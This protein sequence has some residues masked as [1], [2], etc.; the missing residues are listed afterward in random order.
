M[1]IIPASSPTSP[2]SP[3]PTNTPPDPV[4]YTSPSK[5]ASTLNSAL[6]KSSESLGAERDKLKRTHS[7]MTNSAAT[8]LFCG[9][10]PLLSHPIHRPPV[11][12]L[13]TSLQRSTSQEDLCFKRYVKIIAPNV[14]CTFTG[15]SPQPAVRER[16]FL[17]YHIEFVSQYVN[18]NEFS[19]GPLD[20]E[21][22][23]QGKSSSRHSANVCLTDNDCL[24]LIQRVYNR[25]RF[26]ITRSFTLEDGYSSESPS[27]EGFLNKL[28]EAM[29]QAKTPIE[30]DAAK[31]IERVQSSFYDAAKNIVRIQSSFYL[32]KGKYR[33]Y[34]TSTATAEMINVIMKSSPALRNLHFTEAVHQKIIEK[35]KAR[36]QTNALYDLAS[37]ARIE[38]ANWCLEQLPTLEIQKEFND[39]LTQIKPE[40][41]FNF[42][43]KFP[44]F[45]RIYAI[46]KYSSTQAILTFLYNCN[47]PEI[48]LVTSIDS[49]KNLLDPTP[50]ET[51]DRNQN[52]N[53]FTLK[54]SSRLTDIILPLLRNE[55]I[56]IV[57][58][59]K[60][61]TKTQELYC[62][63]NPAV[64]HHTA[65]NNSLKCDIPL[66]RSSK[67]SV[68]PNFSSWGACA[69]YITTDLN[70]S[71]TGS[72]RPN[73]AHSDLLKKRDFAAC[74]EE[75]IKKEKTKGAKCYTTVID[76][77][78]KTAEGMP[79]FTKKILNNIK[80]NAENYK[81]LSIFHSS[82]INSETYLQ[83]YAIGVNLK[84]DSYLTD[85]A[86][87]YFESIGG[88][89][90][91]R[92]RWHQKN[93]PDGV[94]VTYNLS[95]K[96]EIEKF[97]L[98]LTHEW[99]CLQKEH[100]GMF[101][102]FNSKNEPE[103]I[104]IVE[105]Q[106]DDS[107]KILSTISLPHPLKLQNKRISQNG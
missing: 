84:F 39:F 54:D 22:T 79:V 53:K 99:N 87:P 30:Q 69:R 93:Y 10:E 89:S 33:A 36:K 63:H 28:H 88:N 76:R 20:I 17:R 23:I 37:C 95:N 25:K 56:E 13:R 5:F 100:Q 51:E 62:Y 91:E 75:N 45:E 82:K 58:I 41:F 92:S 103:K 31:N 101:V 50:F 35:A 64:W 14:S 94:E 16:A 83:H 29:L 26:E 12:D 21:K 104:F 40:S 74:Y 65:A 49:A 96:D 44:N 85:P 72:E 66:N 60:D 9:A 11:T 18:W 106:V 48:Y 4:H 24:T 1:T 47:S 86:F 57:L 105:D 38:F 52:C 34:L 68:T 102:F 90:K 81:M 107:L 32:A 71:N 73:L 42:Y 43:L 6:R 15:Q 55:K 8:N 46:G 61:T 7:A 59:A 27:P 78:L 77:A 70:S 98:S 19:Q 67:L 2:T 80:K 3:S 97:T